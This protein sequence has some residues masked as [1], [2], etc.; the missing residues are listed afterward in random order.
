MGRH[1][2]MYEQAMNRFNSFWF[3]VV[4]FA[5]MKISGFILGLR[6]GR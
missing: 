5:T 3:V 4:H 6:T 2:L 1:R